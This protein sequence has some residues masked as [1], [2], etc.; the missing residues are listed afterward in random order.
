MWVG[1]EATLLRMTLGTPSDGKA[2]RGNF[3]LSRSKTWGPSQR[4][5]MTRFPGEQGYEN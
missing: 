5:A 4:R 2:A 1:W 3:P